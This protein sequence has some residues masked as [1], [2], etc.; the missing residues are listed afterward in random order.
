MSEDLSRC[1]LKAEDE[2]KVAVR[3]LPAQ[4]RCEAV[5]HCY[6]SFFWIVRGLLLDKDIH[7]KTH[8]G[9]ETQFSNL[10]LMLRHLLSG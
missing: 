9:V 4:L 7:A 3:L 5:N 1:L 8:S 2:C 6:Y 10:Y